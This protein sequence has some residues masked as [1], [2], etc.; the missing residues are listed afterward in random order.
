MTGVEIVQLVGAVWNV[1]APIAQEMVA[2][3]LGGGDP[4]DALSKE[5]VE[6]IL[7]ASVRLDLAMRAD[8]AAKAHA[9]GA[10]K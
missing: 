10:G 6:A 8:A 9:A 2:T 7:P 5:R 4:L 3:A 1:L